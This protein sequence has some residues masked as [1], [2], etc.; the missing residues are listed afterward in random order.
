M[1]E[2]GTTFHGKRRFVQAVVTVALASGMLL[3][4]YGSAQ[5]ATQAHATSKVTAPAAAAA[6]AQSRDDRLALQM[7]EDIVHGNYAAATAHFDATMR[8]Q[9]PPAA[10]A[11]A[12][13]SYQEEFGRY[14]SHQAPKDVAFG[15]FTVVKVPLRMERRPGEFRVSFHKDGTVAGLFFLKPGVPVST[16]LTARRPA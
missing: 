15:G 1:F 14:R 3:P 7:L 13:K 16:T 9:L 6:I 11:K 4:A 5:A 2:K 12:W 10:L 8:R